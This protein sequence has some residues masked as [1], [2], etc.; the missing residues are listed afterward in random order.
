[1]KE[2]VIQL[3]WLDI[4]SISIAIIYLFGNLF[5]FMIWWRDK[6]KL[7]IPMQS[8]LVALF[9]D[10]KS[11]IN[12]AYLVQQLLFSP[13]NPHKDLATLKW[14]YYEFTMGVIGCLQGFQEAVVGVLVKLNPEDRDGRAAFR[15]SDYGLTE[16]EK[17]LRE[18]NLK[19]ILKQM[20]TETIQ[21]KDAEKQASE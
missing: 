21:M 2:V 11:K 14:K 5:Q 17:K 13:Q 8:A 19:R 1:M 9:N 20:T 16:Q 15:A 10:I 6:K 12:N 4:V 7:Y 18:E 3:T